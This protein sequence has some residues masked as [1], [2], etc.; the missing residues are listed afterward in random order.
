MGVAA[1]R[2]HRGLLTCPLLSPKLRQHACMLCKLQHALQETHDVT[3]APRDAQWWVEAERTVSAR[4][5]YSSSD[6]LAGTDR[7]GPGGP[8]MAAQA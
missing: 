4:S 2:A 6:R 5:L 3:A 1:A 8:F 7:M